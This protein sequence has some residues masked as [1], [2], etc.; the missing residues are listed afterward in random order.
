[1]NADDHSGLQDDLRNDARTLGSAARSRVADEVDG[2]KGTATRQV[3]SAASALQAAERELDDDS[4]EWLR[5]MLRSGSQSL[6]RMAD[7]V[8]SKSAREL[9]DD[10]QHM[11]RSNPVM[12]W[13]LCAAAGF[14]AV[15]VMKAG[16]ISTHRS[17]S[18]SSWDNPRNRMTDNWSE[19]SSMARANNPGADSN[20]P[21]PDRG[22]PDTAAGR[23]FNVNPDDNQVTEQEPA[24]NADYRE[25]AGYGRAPLPDSAEKLNRPQKEPQSW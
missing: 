19:D 22:T 1:M 20:A 6:Q 25:Q 14:A 4:P 21:R 10:V 13:G 11:A 3:K 5:A 24:E 17:G 8:E 2:R 15:R 12:F 16:G 18:G 7:Q 23:N 9:M